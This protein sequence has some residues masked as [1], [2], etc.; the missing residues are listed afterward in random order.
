MQNLT[1]GDVSDEFKNLRRNWGMTRVTHLLI[2]TNSQLIANQVRG[3]FQMKDP[4]LIKYLQKALK[5]SETVEEFGINHIPMEENVS[6]DLLAR[7]ASTKGVGLKKTV[8]QE[9]M[10][11]PST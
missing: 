4:S 8:I 6:V 1:N 7:L 9:T 3:E 10:E 2:Q 5:M 11:S